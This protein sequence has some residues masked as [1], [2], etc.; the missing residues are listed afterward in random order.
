M[1]AWKPASRDQLDLRRERQQALDEV[2]YLIEQRFYDNDDLKN[3]T[4][5]V[6]A[7][8]DGIEPQLTGVVLQAKAGIVDVLDN[9]SRLQTEMAS[10]QTN[11]IG[12]DTDIK[13][14]DN[15]LELQKPFDPDG[16]SDAVLLFK[17]G[18]YK[19]SIDSFKK[20]LKKKPPYFLQDNIHFGIGTSYYKLKKMKQAE[21]IFAMIVNK[22]PEGDKWPT[23][24]VMMGLIYNETG[25]KSKAIYELQRALG[26]HMR[27]KNRV[28][29]ERLLALIQ[30]DSYAGS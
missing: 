7:S 13:K 11:G 30:Q 28:L 19:E 24:Y 5:M 10:V 29:V 25:R 21:K 18:S 15:Y 3:F 2:A 6:Q 23:A 4:Q 27:P 12:L 8:A 16:Y 20:L 14:Y 22:Y 17:K 1:Y 9:F 26:K